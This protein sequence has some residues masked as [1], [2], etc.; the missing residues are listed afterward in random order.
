MSRSQSSTV[1]PPPQPVATGTG[2]QSTPDFIDALARGL[3]VIQA[4]SSDAPEMTLTEV[5]RRTGLS[6]ATARRCLLTLK[7]LGYV[8]TN[9][10]NFLLRQ[11]V[12]SLG[13]A[14]LNSM[15]MRNVADAYL[16]DLAE[17]F[18]DAASMAVL[19]GLEVLYIAHVPSRREPRF[20]VGIG[21][22]LPAYATSM[23]HVLLAHLEPE[24]HADFLARAPFTA[25]T[26]R[27]TTKASELKRI[28][29]SVKAKGYAA[30]ED[31]IEFGSIAVAV[32][33]RDMKGRVFA[34]INC[35]ADTSRTSLETLVA[36]RVPKLLAAASQIEDAT[37]RYPAL[38]HSIVTGL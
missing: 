25:Y 3:E 19:E 12:L 17:T 5:A 2:R 37:S 23:G 13:A 20:R 15:N 34:A 35:S 30:V 7:E 14:F 1:F 33:V 32:P 16:Q 38:I 11:K 8:G 26:P 4:F 6:P 27:T 29:Q 18:H 10:R 9:G 22:R 31:Q 21:S 36:T 24:R 28:F